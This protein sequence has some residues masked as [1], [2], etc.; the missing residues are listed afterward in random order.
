MFKTI[1]QYELKLGIPP[2]IFGADPGEKTWLAFE[3]SIHTFFFVVEYLTKP[4]EGEEEFGGMWVTLYAT[5]LEAVIDLI[6]DDRVLESRINL[7]IP[8]HSSDKQQ[9][10]LKPITDIYEYDEIFVD[11][12]DEHPHKSI[13]Y[14]TSDG[15]RYLDSNLLSRESELTSKPVTLYSKKDV[16]LKHRPTFDEADDDYNEE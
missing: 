1:P 4:M 12:D 7:S 14:V 9:L 5:H 3:Q 8:V 6:A 11:G 2:E 15:A 13:V 10:E 16:T